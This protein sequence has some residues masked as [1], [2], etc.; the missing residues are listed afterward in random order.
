MDGTSKV[1]VL[2]RHIMADLFTGGATI[3]GTIAYFKKFNEILVADGDSTSPVSLV[4]TDSGTINLTQE[5]DKRSI[6][7]SGFTGD[8][9]MTTTTG[10]D[11]ILGNDGNDT[12]NAG[13]GNDTLNGGTGDDSLIGGQGD[14]SFV[15]TDALSGHDSF[16]GGTGN[17]QLLLDSGAPLHL[18][19]LVVTAAAGVEVLNLNG[20]ELGGTVGDD[21]FD[22]S[23]ISSIV[24]G[25]GLNLG[26]GNDT[27]RGS[28]TDDQIFGGG[29]D[30]DL[31]GNSG[32]DTLSGGAGNDT[33]NGGAGDDVFLSGTG[34]A[35]FDS[36]QGG[37][38]N[39]TLV[40]DG[41]LT[42]PSRLVLNAAASVE[43]LEALAP[44]ATTG[45][46]NDFWDI[47]GVTSYATPFLIDFG[48]G[49]DSF[50]G[51]QAGDVVQGGSDNDTLSGNDGDDDLSG[52][53]GNDVLSGGAG[54]DSLTGEAGND[55]LD[56]G[57]GNDVL[58]GGLGDDTYL[59]GL[60]DTV[61]ETAL[62]GRDRIVLQ[63]QTR[64]TLGANL[65]DL[66][67]TGATAVS[68]TGNGLANAIT[69]SSGNDSLDGRT[70]DDTMTG[71]AG[72]DLYRVDSLGDVVVEAVGG[73][74]DTIRTALV[75]YK[76]TPQIE[77]LIGT[78]N[79]GQALTGNGAANVISGARGADTINGGFGADLM[80]GGAGND[81][82]IVDNA[83]DL[84]F[85]KR[86]G[87]LDTVST[88]LASYTL[89]ANVE[90]LIGIRLHSQALTGNTKANTV[91]GGNGA[92]RLSG[93][94]GNDLLTGG[95]GADK[96]EFRTAIGTGNLDHIT[97]F[98]S[99]DTIV[100]E[101]SDAGLFNT[102]ALGVLAA[103]DF[104]LVGPGGAAVDAS[105][106]I[107]YNQ[108]TG[109][110]YYDADGSGIAERVKFAVL[111]SLPVLTS[112]DILV[113]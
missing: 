10:N 87:G 71:G 110:L 101:N 18:D 50:V 94:Q 58:T 14:D 113:I 9:L 99:E 28:L 106:R 2:E 51:S 79:A 54:N 90:N 16:F 57:A 102:L 25:T 6:T 19:W 7:L 32:D 62:G 13:D 97:D 64:F 70:G 73:G 38:G 85:E 53:N 22:L 26:E 52:G 81:S 104:K 27:F 96:F 46:G 3:S 34:D 44:T 31:S 24:G 37:L 66:T 48:A 86:T 92:D 77:N 59:L 12:I 111:D 17:D 88:A 95:A 36:L 15:I 55:M 84:I 30:D 63:G 75:V 43:R 56:G 93:M 82:Y 80:K 21:L 100:L 11:L 49:N 65:E 74:T 40:L 68:L 76:L 112:A 42:S 69:G 41:A 103:E 105:D 98:A 8:D 83:A 107:L 47:S 78:N 108:S 35:G 4:L 33:L 61:F 91:T 29:G 20:V 39:D 109:A 1:T 5:L 23:G 67:A 45:A 72:D 60:G 89:S